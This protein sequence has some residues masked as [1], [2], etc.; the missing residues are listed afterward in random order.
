MFDVKQIHSKI[1]QMFLYGVSE[2]NQ[3]ILF[4]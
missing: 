3:M 2:G 4:L 1:R